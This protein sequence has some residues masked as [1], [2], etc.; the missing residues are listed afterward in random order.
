[1]RNSAA[2]W[3]FSPASCRVQFSTNSFDSTRIIPGWLKFELAFWQGATFT[4]FPDTVLDRVRVEY[5][6]RVVGRS[7]ST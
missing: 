2:R 4:A 5:M 1:V 7:V 6:E 3:C